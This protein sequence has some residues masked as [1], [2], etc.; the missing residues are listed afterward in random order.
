MTT[1][2]ELIREWQDNLDTLSEYD[3]DSL[4][5]EDH[6]VPVLDADGADEDGSGLVSRERYDTQIAEREYWRAACLSVEQQLKQAKREG[7]DRDDEHRDLVHALCGIIA[8]QTKRLQTLTA[9]VDMH[10]GQVDDEI[11]F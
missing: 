1:I 2:G 7:H 8:D 6:R 5:T 4:I 9:I 10:P 3:V 11:P